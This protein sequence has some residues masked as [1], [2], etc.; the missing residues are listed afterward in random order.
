M[1]KVTETG[2]STEKTLER[3]SRELHRIGERLKKRPAMR[4]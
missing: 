3:V 1:N 2:Q 4:V